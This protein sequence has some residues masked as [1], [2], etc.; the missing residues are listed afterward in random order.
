[1]LAAWILTPATTLACSRCCA[2]TAGTRP[3]SRCSNLDFGTGSTATMPASAMSTP[4]ARGSSPARRSHRSSASPRC[5]SGSS[6]LRARHI[7]A[8]CG[9]APR[10]GFASRP[11][12]QR[13]GSAISRCGIRAGGRRWS[14]AARVCASSCGGRARR[15]WWCARSRSTSSRQTTRPA[16]RSTR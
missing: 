2:A 10:S 8:R 14:R 5:R 9:S 12:G 4:A 15:A 13:C 16:C 1:M 3:R 6:T 11:R 7:A